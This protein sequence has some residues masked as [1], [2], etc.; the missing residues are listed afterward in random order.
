MQ[1]FKK[2]ITSAMVFGIQGL[3]KKS[4]RFNRVLFLSK[5]KLLP[6]AEPYTYRIRILLHTCDILL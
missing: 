1:R 2:L 5:K 4:T 3:Q 6:V